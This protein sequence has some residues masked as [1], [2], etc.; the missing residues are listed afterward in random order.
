MDTVGF[1]LMLVP[2][3]LTISAPPTSRFNSDSA[4]TRSGMD[5]YQSSGENW[6]V[7]M[8]EPFPSRAARRLNSSLAVSPGV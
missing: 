8:V 3:M 4:T 1:S 2:S 6:E 7:T 5:S